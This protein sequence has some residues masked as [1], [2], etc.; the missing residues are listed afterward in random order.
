MIVDKG[1]THFHFVTDGIQNASTK[2]KEAN[3]RVKVEDSL[4]V[5]Y[6]L[7]LCMQ[8]FGPGFDTRLL[9]RFQCHYQALKSIISIPGYDLWLVMDT[10]YLCKRPLHVEAIQ[11]CTSTRV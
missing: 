8:I 5:S 1:K 3:S 10:K 11:R 9:S 4:T 6:I 2:A 7:L